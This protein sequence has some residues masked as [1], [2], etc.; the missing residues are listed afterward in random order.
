M[1]KI[2]VIFMGT[3]QFSV[4]VL[5]GLLELDG[6]EVV[7]VVTQPDKPS[8]RGNEVTQSPIKI[9][10][11][12]KNIPALQPEK[13]TPEVV[14]SIGKLNPDIIVV[15][16]YGHIIPKSLIEIPKYKCIN[17][18]GSLLPKYRGAHP[19]YWITGCLL[20]AKRLEV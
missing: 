7:G 8:G 4:P 1:N 17:I 11:A 12:S 3:P 19:H 9:L 20:K 18:H 13:I 15:A 2:K 16:A 6:F 5:E 14:E 10:A